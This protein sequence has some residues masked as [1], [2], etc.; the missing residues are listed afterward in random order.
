L[1]DTGD[2]KKGAPGDGGIQKWSLTGGTW[3][4]DY[5]LIDPNFVTDIT[6]LHGETGFEALTGEIV[7]SGP[8]AQVELFA[9]SY[10]LG[11]GD[12]NGLY[13]ITDN[14]DATT[15]SGESFTEMETSG[16]NDVFKGVSFAPVPEPGMY[17][18]ILGGLG[19][20]AALGRRRWKQ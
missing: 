6:Q 14:L 4:L 18:L 3:T 20:L 16:A 13:T 7:G 17:G 15:E 8:S 11:D 9:V 12:P 19:A 2:P 1:A 5:T 10:T